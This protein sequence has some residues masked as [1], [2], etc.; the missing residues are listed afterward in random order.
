MNTPT[1]DGLIL[2]CEDNKMNQEV[3]S[4]R[5]AKLGLKTVTASNGRECVEIV[6]DRVKNSEKPF[7]LIFMDILMPVMDGVDATT[8]IIKLNT[9]TP[10][11]AMTSVNISSDR[12]KYISCGMS[13]CMSKPFTS[14][15]LLECLMKYLTP[16][17]TGDEDE[18]P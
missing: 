6:Q 8:E 15:E 11:I 5:F 18:T 16:V 1:F 17:Y 2:L 7:D 3:I 10:I 13:E 14:K 4:S 9:G 12:E